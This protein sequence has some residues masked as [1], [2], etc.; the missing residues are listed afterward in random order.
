MKHLILML[1]LVTTGCTNTASTPISA[2]HLRPLVELERVAVQIY[3]TN[4][5]LCRAANCSP[6]L[7][8]DQSKNAPIARSDNDAIYFSTYWMESPYAF[9]SDMSRALTIG[10]EWSH[11][12]LGHKK[13]LFGLNQ[14]KRTRLTA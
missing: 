10:R 7:K 11:I 8:L 12:L 13:G 6:S 2:Q 1:G 3:T 5:D 4:T 14:S 9:E